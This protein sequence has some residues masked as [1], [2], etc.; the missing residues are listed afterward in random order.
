MSLLAP[1]RCSLPRTTAAR[2]GQRRIAEFL[3]NL[4]SVFSKASVARGSAGMTASEIARGWGFD[5]LAVTIESRGG[6]AFKR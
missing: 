1:G 4:P 6:R 3:L 5:D 2:W